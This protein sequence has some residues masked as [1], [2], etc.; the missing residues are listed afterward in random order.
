VNP[1]TVVV[2]VAGAPVDL[3]AA[4]AS[5]GAILWSWFNGSQGGNALADVILGKVN[6]SGKLPFTLPA[7]LD[8][9]PAH[10]LGTFP[11]DSIAEYKEGILVGYRWFDTKNV[12][13]L[14]HFGHGLSYSKFIY[15]DL[16]TDKKTYQSNGVIKIS[17]RLKNEGPIAGMDVVQIYVKDMK[18]LVPKASKE[19]K[20]FKKVL[21]ESGNTKLIELEIPVSELSYYDMNLARWNLTSGSYEIMAGSSS[22]DIR[23]SCEIRIK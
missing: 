16:K 7:L 14:Y 13:P 5:A 8:D 19:L 9:S 10:A 22:G 11:G 4:N 6:P 18:P 1:R 17:L 3:H 2:V 23:G 21:V 20:A 12:E 15:S